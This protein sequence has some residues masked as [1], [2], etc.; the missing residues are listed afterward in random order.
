MEEIF[1]PRRL[2]ALYV[3]TG[4]GSSLVSAVWRLGGPVYSVG[5]SGA[6]CGLIGAAAA[7]GWMRGGRSGQMIKGQMIQWAIY[8]LVT[9]FIIPFTD[10]AAH[11]GGLISGALLGLVLRDGQHRTAAAR[12]AW[13]AIA[14]LCA[15]LVL[16]AFIMV[17]LHYESTIQFV[18]RHS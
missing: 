3:A 14:W 2:L 1:G 5:A 4:I 11:I 7:W 13:E 10:N 8:I 16:G 17:G 18:L 6:I 12:A 15:L 9:G